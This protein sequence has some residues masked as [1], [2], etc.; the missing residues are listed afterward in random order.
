MIYLVPLVF[1]GGGLALLIWGAENVIRAAPS[2]AYKMRIPPIAAGA[3]ILG[4]G[5]SLPE[6][7]VSLTAGLRGES[8][9][10]YG[11]AVGSNIAN[12]GFIL[13]ITALIYPIVFVGRVV[14]RQ[15]LLMGLA[16]LSFLVLSADLHLSFLDASFLFVLLLFSLWAIILS[17]MVDKPKGRILS[18]AAMFRRLGGGMLCLG[19][20]APLTI[21]GVSTLA[22]SLGIPS[23]LVGLTILAVG[24]SLPELVVSIQMAIRKEP[25]LA[26]GNILGSQIFNLLLVVPL[27]CILHPIDITNDDLMRDGGFLVLMTLMGFV[28]CFSWNGRRTL[29]AFA[30]LLLLFV[31]CSYLGIIAAAVF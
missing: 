23:Q 17:K 30:A 1:F 5:T 12:I 27:A 28:L 24:T 25:H 2:V 20:G 3:I 21:E 14:R 15:F 26:I 4:L 13:G 9:I 29:G 8:L 16:T 31:Y 7:L 10:A 19:V 6:A 22:V 18:N 11:N